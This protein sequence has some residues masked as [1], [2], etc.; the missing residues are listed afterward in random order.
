[1]PRY[2]FDIR[3]GPEFHPD[4]NGQDLPDLET[5]EREAAVL[6]ASIGSYVL[7]KRR[8]PSVVVEVRNEDGQRVATVT[9]SLSLERAEP[10][11][12]SRAG[13]DVTS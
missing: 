10:P 4:Q 13:T 12:T 3:E 5:A 7:P 6:A 8:I 11:L 9:L 2:Y 1:M